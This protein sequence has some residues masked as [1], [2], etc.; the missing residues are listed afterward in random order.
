VRHG[1]RA[2]RDDART[3]AGAEKD[4]GGGPIRDGAPGGT[5]PPW[6]VL[7]ELPRPRPP[8]GRHA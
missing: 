4:A 6:A 2:G 1:Y 7:W 8:A 3:D 5:P